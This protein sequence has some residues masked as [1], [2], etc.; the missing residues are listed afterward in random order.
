MDLFKQQRVEDFYE[1]GEELGRYTDS[2][3][4]QRISPTSMFSLIKRKM[5]RSLNQNPNE[6]LKSHNVSCITKT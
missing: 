6:N 3:R 4:M 2:Q 5:F 1:I